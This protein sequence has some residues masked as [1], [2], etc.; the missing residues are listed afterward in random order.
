MMNMTA[1]ELSN[2]SR[3]FVIMHTYRCLLR[4]HRLKW[5][6]HIGELASLVPRLS[7]TRLSFVER[8]RRRPNAREILAYQMIFGVLPEELFPGLVAEVEETLL[9]KAYLLWQKYEHDT[10][11]R[12]KRKRKFL[13]TILARAASRAG[14]KGK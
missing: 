8:G 5:E 9:R 14:Q 6:L 12:G 1:R 7:E 11:A 2:P 3:L 4:A 10:S 13:E